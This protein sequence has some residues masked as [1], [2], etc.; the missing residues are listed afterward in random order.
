MIITGPAVR[1]VPG[2]GD[3]VMILRR[4][5]VQE[6]RPILKEEVYEQEELVDRRYR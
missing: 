6:V 4:G 5:V 2:D 3:S 1:R